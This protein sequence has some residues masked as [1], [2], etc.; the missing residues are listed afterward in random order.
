MT[1][2]LSDQKN[3]IEYNLYEQDFY[4]WIKETAN[5]LR[6]GKLQE[7][8]LENLIEEIEAMGR[9][10][11]KS[12]T[13]NLRILLMH[14]LKY[15]YQPEKITN[16]WKYTI[17]EHRNRIKKAFKYSPSLKVLFQD[18]FAECYQEAIKLAADETGL[19]VNTF[20]QECLFSLEQVLDET[21][22]P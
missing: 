22:L 10:E 16:S 12:V 3:K 9:S 11:K 20:S 14:L 2:Q 21:Y 5:L 19:S 8:D 15:K 17:R 13:S 4:L 18:V 7:V 6:Q 1:S